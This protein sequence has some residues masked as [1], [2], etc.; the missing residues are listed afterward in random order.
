[1]LSRPC[2]EP[3]EPTRSVRSRKT[4]A[5]ASGAFASTTI[6]RSAPSLVTYVGWS[7]APGIHSS[8]DTL[9]AWACADPNGI[10]RL[11]QASTRNRHGY[12]HRENVLLTGILLSIGRRHRHNQHL[13]RI[14]RPTSSEH[15]LS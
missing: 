2:S 1:M 5:P 12:D 9:G 3:S 10:N 14:L 6:K 11:N 7:K 15:D 8:R 13:T 4:R